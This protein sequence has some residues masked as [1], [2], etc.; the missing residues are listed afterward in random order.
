MKMHHKVTAIGGL[1]AGMLLSGSAL[2]APIQ[3][4]PD[5]TLNHMIMD[6]SQAAACLD[7]G[8]GNLTGNATNDPFLTGVGSD[9]E[10]IEKS[11]EAPNPYNLTYS[12]D[13]SYYG[14]WSFD[15]DFWNDYSDAAIGFK[16]GTGNTPDE[17]FV[18]SLQALVSSG[19]WAF[20]FGSSVDK[21]TG[22]GLS[23]VNLYAKEPVT[24]A[25][26]GTIALLGL[27][28]V[29][30]GLARRKRKAG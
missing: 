7:S 17:W 9:Y 11:D 2:G 29:G 5:A 12:Q 16:F 1:A 21:E 24:V 28:L 30:L 4:S 13:G 22:G 6:D 25:E 27:G 14:T 10:L 15:S 23:H 3:C 18:F 26:P 20:F 8:V 19:E